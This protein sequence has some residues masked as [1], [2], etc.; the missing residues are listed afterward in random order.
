MGSGKI[1]HTKLEM[2]NKKFFRKGIYF[3]KDIKKKI[4][5][6]IWITSPFLRPANKIKLNDYKKFIGKNLKKM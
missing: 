2:K 1:N 6:S 4:L 3:S 5:K